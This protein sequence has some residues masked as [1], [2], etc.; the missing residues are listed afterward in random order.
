MKEVTLLLTQSP[1]VEGLT[2][3]EQRF[4]DI[5]EIDNTL[6]RTQ[7]SERLSIGL[8]SVKEYLRKL[9]EKGYLERIG[10]NKSTGRWI[11]K[12]E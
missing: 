2:E 11:V 1:P 7:M 4:L 10:G 6:S 8:D 12:R 5:L 3:L 9:R